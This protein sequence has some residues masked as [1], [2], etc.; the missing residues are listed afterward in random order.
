MIFNATA[1]V[2]KSL[3]E[4]DNAQIGRKG[5]SESHLSGWKG[6][7]ELKHS[8]KFVNEVSCFSKLVREIDVAQVFIKQER[9]AF[10]RENMP[11]KCADIRKSVRIGPVR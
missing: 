6:R 4:E 5:E 10:E 9:I 3:I 1:V 7:K 2:I 11:M 8:D